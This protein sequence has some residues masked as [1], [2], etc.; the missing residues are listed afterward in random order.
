M[1]KRL[2]SFDDSAFADKIKPYRPSIDLKTLPENLEE[3]E[4]NKFEM[5]SYM[6]GDELESNNL[7]MVE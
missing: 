6:D 7:A 1:Q 4:D 3:E 5:T 2:D